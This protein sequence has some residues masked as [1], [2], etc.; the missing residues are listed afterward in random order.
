MRNKFSVLALLLLFS[1]SALDPLI[2]A[3]SEVA[4][5]VEDQHLDVTPSTC[6]A[7]KFSVVTSSPTL[8]KNFYLFIENLNKK[9]IKLSFSEKVVLLSM[10]QMSQ[11]PHIVSPYSKISYALRLDKDFTYQS[12]YSD[13]HN[14]MPYFYSLENILKQG[15]SKKSLKQLS[16]LIKKHYKYEILVEPDLE[17]FI[18]ENRKDLK[19]QF[20]FSSI[21]FKGRQSV[22]KGESLPLLKIE[23]LLRNYKVKSAKHYSSNDHVFNSPFGEDT[24]CNYDLNLYKHGVYLN[25]NNKL[26]SVQFMISE[27]KQLFVAISSQKITQE[28]SGAHKTYSIRGR[29]K[30]AVRGAFCSIKTGPNKY[31]LISSAKDR[32]PAQLIYNIILEYN[33]GTTNLEKLVSDGRYLKLLNPRR[34]IAETNLLSSKQIDTLRENSS[35]IYHKKSLGNIFI[36]KN[37]RSTIEPIIDGRGTSFLV[38]K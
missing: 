25:A 30:D 18:Q 28:L 35:P 15:R 36:I 17:E 27:G 37:Y 11:S 4:D 7:K 2:E 8:S 29:S 9:N 32:D 12:I 16:N 20:P 21:F 34:I 26:K 23:K 10:L 24:K 5:Q 1:C 14:G 3:D 33:N 31:S 13:N 6:K 38:C 22:R 19:K